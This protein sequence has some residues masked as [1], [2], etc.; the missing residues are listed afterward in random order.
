MLRRFAREWLVVLA[1][2]LFITSAVVVVWAQVPG[3]DPPAVLDLRTYIPLGTVLLIVSPII[4]GWR[5]WAGLQQRSSNIEASVLVLTKSVEASVL[6][7][8]KSVEFHS[9]NQDIHR[10][11]EAL[12]KE[13][14]PNRVCTSNH[15]MLTMQL[16]NIE[17]SAARIE[18]SQHEAVQRA[19]TAGIAAALQKSKE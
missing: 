8:A 17:G 1:S 3:A 16:K 14:M 13:F 9:S 6:V 5:A 12:Q 15:E 19:I 2:F 7:L 4:A 10:G 11:L 18:G